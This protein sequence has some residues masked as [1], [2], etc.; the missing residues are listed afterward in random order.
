VANATTWIASISGAGI[1]IVDFG[2]VASDAG[3]RA[4]AEAGAIA[5]VTIVAALSAADRVVDD[6]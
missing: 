6:A 1:A 2:C 3:A 4:V 5:D